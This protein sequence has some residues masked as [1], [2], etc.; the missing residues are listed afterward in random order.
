M[1]LVDDDEIEEAGRELAKE[2]LALLRPGDCL[3]EAEI[4]LVGGVDAPSPVN[5]VGQLPGRAVRTFDGLRFRGQL[6]HRRTEGPEVVDHCLVDQHVAIGEEQD[7]FLAAGLPESPDDLER[8][9]RLSRAG[10]HDQQDAVGALGDRFDGGVDGVD[11]VVARRLAAAIVVVVLEDDGL[12]LGRQS[13][14]VAIARPQVVG[15]RESVEAD[16]GFLLGARACP[17][18]EDEAVAVGRKHEGNLQGLRVV[19]SLLHAVANGVGVVLGFDEGDGDVGLVVEDVVG[20][21]ALASAGQLAAYDD[22]A[23]CEAD[24]LADLRHLVPSDPAQGR[25][26]E[27]GADVAFAETFLVHEDQFITCPGTL[28]CLPSSSAMGG[29]REGS[30]GASVDDARHRA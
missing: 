3:V 16:G 29:I 20:S 1:A 30:L 28:T 11:L 27:L 9:V 19:Q 17:V 14:P 22:S 25:S 15:R 6:G 18:V 7:A 23:L 21:L 4:D 10:R 13:L 8:G 26:D 2:L 24:L 5:G 12:G